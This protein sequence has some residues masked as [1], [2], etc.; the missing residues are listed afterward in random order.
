[1][2]PMTRLHELERT[3][4]FMGR[5]KHG[6]DLLEELTAICREKQIELGRVSAIGAVSKATLAYYDQV[7]REYRPVTIDR[8]LEITALLGNISLRDGEPIVHAHLT[9]ADENGGA[10]GGHLSPGTIIFA[11]E[12]VIDVFN[13]PKLERGHDE[14]T[15][16]PLWKNR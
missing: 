13:G 4:T 1:M 7:G 16:L 8:H 14:K 11:C 9:L 10:F 2:E 12:V 15:G 5:L 3:G 6:G